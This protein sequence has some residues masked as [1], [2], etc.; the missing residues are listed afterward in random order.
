MMT[1]ATRSIKSLMNRVN[2]CLY[3]A[4]ISGLLLGK[5]CPI[6]SC[7]VVFLSL[8]RVVSWFKCGT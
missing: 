5:G 1:I 4:Y 2:G 3:F 8:S 6:G 7:S